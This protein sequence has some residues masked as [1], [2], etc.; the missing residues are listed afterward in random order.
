[1]FAFVGASIFGWRLGAAQPL[2]LPSD[3]LTLISIAYFFTLLFGFVSTAFVGRWMAPTYG[4]RNAFGT[5][6]ALVGIVAAPMVAGSICHLFPHVFINLLVFIP[7]LIWSMYLLYKGL[8]IILKTGPERGNAD[9]VCADRLPAG[10]R[11]DPSRL[12]RRPLGE[13]HR[14]VLRRLR[15]RSRRKARAPTAPD[16]KVEAS[17]AGSYRDRVVT[18][19]VAFSIFWSLLGMAAGVHIAAEPV[20][21]SLDFGHEWLSFGRLPSAACVRCIPTRSS[22]DSASRR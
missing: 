14:P 22:S 11:R 13:R 15:W 17:P 12:D 8:P 1:M 20:W 4:A 16:F 9:G 2:Y 10:R 18:A 19:L 3:A 5:H 6:L 7:A 21:P